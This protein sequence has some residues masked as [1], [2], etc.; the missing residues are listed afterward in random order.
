MLTLN[1][2][3]TYTL[4]TLPNGLR[5]FTVP[6]PDRYSVAL[7][8]YLGVGSRYE[9]AET[10]G[11]SHFLEHMLFKGS[12][13]YP[14]P[15]K[16]SLAVEGVGGSLDGFTTYAR[17]A[18][19][20]R[21]PAAHY[22]TA[23]DVLADMLR[24]PRL[25]AADVAKERKVIQEELSMVAD[26]PESWLTL[27]ADELMFGDHPLGRPVHGTEASLR[28]MRPATLQAHL[29]AFYRPN[30]TVVALVG[31]F[32]P[33]QALDAVAARLGDWTPGPTPDFLPAPA[34]PPGPRVRVGTRS[35]EQAH[36]RLTVPGLSM[37]DPDRHI[38]QVLSA[39]LGD[40]M[41]S[42]LFLDLR[43]RSALA[44]NVYSDDGYEHDMGALVLYAA[45]D[46]P[47]ATRAVRAMLGHLWR[48]RDEPVP[49]AELVKTKEYLKGGLL[50]SLEDTAEIADSLASQAVVR[51]E[52]LTA[53]DL[54]ERIER[55]TPA[56]IQRVARRLLH[57][58]QLHLTIVGPFEGQDRFLALLKEGA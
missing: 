51:E 46:P 15:D 2:A 50:L 34:L 7:A 31:A 4:T 40:G 35:I 30:N 1:L 21:V 22:V 41:S 44:Y 39:L 52:I 33:A 49:E 48:L 28:A 10:A 57:P 9:T 29:D 58:E 5:V 17:T 13:R 6:L 19:S 26:E 47:R 42:R 16:I 54:V 37:F 3:D 20:A 24:S 8:V 14:T 36:L 11:V 38:L 18:Y 23:L 25:R 27:L 12:Q 43:E 53:G 55:V 32:D 45:V 56:D